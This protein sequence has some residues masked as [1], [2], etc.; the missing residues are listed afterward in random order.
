LLPYFTTAK[1]KRLAE[2]N[3]ELVEE[4]EK[5]SFNIKLMSDNFSKKETEYIIA[6]VI[7]NCLIILMLFFPP[8]KEKIVIKSFFFKRVRSID[9]LQSNNMEIDTGII[10]IITFVIITMFWYF[11]GEKFISIGDNIIFIVILVI[12]IT[13]WYSLG[14]NLV[15]NNKE[16]TLFQII[17]C[18]GYRFPE[19]TFLLIAIHLKSPNFFQGIINVFK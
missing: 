11:V 13:L 6:I 19:R 7:L 1:E 18:A 16:S 8:I 15:L 17:I 2:E 9:G 3:K 10:L 4:N 12:G 14:K 5:L